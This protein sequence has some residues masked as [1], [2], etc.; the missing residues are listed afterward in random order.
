MHYS[1]SAE[2]STR[3]IDVNQAAGTEVGFRMGSQAVEVSME[4]ENHQR[5]AVELRYVT[6]RYQI[7][8]CS[9]P[10]EARQVALAMPLLRW[11]NLNCYVS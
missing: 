2:A 9:E 6:R 4:D 1:V 10:S 3:N 11:L 5:N 7:P 8:F